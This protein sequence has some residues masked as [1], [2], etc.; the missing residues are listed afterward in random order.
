MN[1]DAL[2]ILVALR[3]IYKFDKVGL[4]VV[5]FSNQY[6]DGEIVI[7]THSH[8]NDIMDF[9]RYDLILG[10]YTF[11]ER[12]IDN[13]LNPVFIWERDKCKYVVTLDIHKAHE[14]EITDCVG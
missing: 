3:G 13:D 10:W 5:E 12:L 4:I 6:P 8:Y 2:N 14:A 1:A 11:K 9:F 7:D